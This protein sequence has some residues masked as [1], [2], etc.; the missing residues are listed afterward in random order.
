MT[1]VKEKKETAPYYKYFLPGL[2]TKLFAGI[3]RLPDLCL[4]FTAVAIR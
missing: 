3:G 1:Q 4:V 2:F